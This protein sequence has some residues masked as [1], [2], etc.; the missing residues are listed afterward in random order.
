MRTRSR[1]S[2]LLFLILLVVITSSGCI[3]IHWARGFL[4]DEPDPV[5]YREFQKWRF[6]YYFDSAVPIPQEEERPIHINKNTIWMNISIEIYMEQ[7]MGAVRY[8]DIILS[9]PTDTPGVHKEYETR[10][11]VATA[12]DHIYVPNPR[13][14]AWM[15]SITAV[16]VSIGGINDGYSLEVTTYEPDRRS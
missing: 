1:T 8:I 15:V 2:I 14:G 12:F 11:Y 10:E 13:V 5:E 9:E 3:D 7:T 4:P 16:G 6:E